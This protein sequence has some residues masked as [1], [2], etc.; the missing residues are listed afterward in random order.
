MDEFGIP[1]LAIAFVTTKGAY[2][3]D[4]LV[5]WTEQALTDVGYTNYADIFHFTAIDEDADDVLDS[6]QLFF[7]P[8][9]RQPLSEK[10]VALV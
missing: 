5:R 6:K 3:L 2:R 9:W 8:V 1:L 4:S 10:R 7:A